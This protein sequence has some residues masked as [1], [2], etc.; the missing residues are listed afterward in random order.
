MPSKFVF[1][2]TM[3]NNIFNTCVILSI[4]TYEIIH[5]WYFELNSRLQVKTLPLARQGLSQ[6]SARQGLLYTTVETFDEMINDTLF[7]EVRVQNEQSIR[8]FSVKSV[9]LMGERNRKCV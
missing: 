6:R 5:F 4:P 2:L 7:Y 1:K 3:T 9:I 8:R